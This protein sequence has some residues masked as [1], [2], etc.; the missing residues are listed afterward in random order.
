M[1]GAGGLPTDAHGG[2]IARDTSVRDGEVVGL[3]GPKESGFSSSN[4]DTVGSGPGAGLGSGAGLGAGSA[5]NQNFGAEH[6]SVHHGDSYGSRG[7]GID[8]TG[9]LDQDAHKYE[10]TGAGGPTTG[11]AANTDKFDTDR[12]GATGNSYGATDSYPDLEHTESRKG[13]GGLKGLLTTKDNE[14]T[15]NPSRTGKGAY[16]DDDAHYKTN[17]DGPSGHSALTGREGT[18]EHNPVAQAK[19]D[20]HGTGAHGAQGTHE[21]KGLMDKVKDALHK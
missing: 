14:F 8:R 7:S 15:A 13:T 1:G 12:S 21:K 11:G 6:S 5:Q 9:N 17:T 3:G 4:Q 20:E 19:T 10:S 16:T 2:T 18:T